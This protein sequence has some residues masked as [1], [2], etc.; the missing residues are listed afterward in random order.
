MLS[1]F[2]LAP[3]LSRTWN[4]TD[5][6]MGNNLTQKFRTI[7]LNTVNLKNRMNFNAMELK[8]RVGSFSQMAKF[9]KSDLKKFSLQ[10]RSFT[11]TKDTILKKSYTGGMALIKNYGACGAFVYFGIYFA[12]LGG[13][14]FAVRA[15]LVTGDQ[16]KRVAES[17]PIIRDH[18]ETEGLEKKVDTV[19]GQ[20][21]IGWVICKIIEPLRLF[22]AMALIKPVHR[23][24]W[25]LLVRTKPATRFTSKTKELLNHPQ[26]QSKIQKMTLKMRASPFFKK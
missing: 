12:C 11:A 9:P 13:S 10:K 1:R 19:K 17:L 5:S 22:A 16:V 14:F 6:Q 25:P 18:V 21:F 15:G 24:L 26:V 8:D 23:H 4:F 7:K 3:K 2:A 20:M